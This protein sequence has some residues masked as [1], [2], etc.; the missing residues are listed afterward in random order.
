VDANNETAMILAACHSLIVL[1]EPAAV[2]ATPNDPADPNGLGPA[3][4]TLVGDPIELA[5]MK[6]MYIYVFIY[7]HIFICILLCICIYIYIRICICIHIYIYIRINAHFMICIYMYT[8]ICKD[9]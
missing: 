9:V 8:Y 2:T 4:P 7:M 5:A 3:G 6:G 1:D